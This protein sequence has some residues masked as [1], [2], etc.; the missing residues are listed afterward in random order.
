MGVFA[1]RMGRRG[2][3][4]MSAIALLACVGAASAGA[5][6]VYVGDGA[7]RSYSVALKTEAGRAYVLGLSARASCEYSEGKPVPPIFG[8]SAFPAPRKMR[9]KSRGFS[10]GELSTI[11]PGFTEAHVLANFA[12][13]E[14]TGAY[15]LDFREE[16]VSCET[17]YA[18]S[19]PFEAHR[20]LPIGK[21]RAVSPARGEVRVYYDHGGPTQFF[22]RATPKFVAGLRGAIV[23]ECPIDRRPSVDRPLPLFPR[24]AGA[25]VNGGRFDHRARI[26]GLMLHSAAPYTETIAISGR[27]TKEAVIGTYV[28]V[29]TT[30]PWH[31]RPQRCVTGPLKIAARRYLTARR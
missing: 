22:A 28:R 1:L 10:A 4:V 6:K 5:A 9:V 2:L 30:R 31:G 3:T 23:S 11:G 13:D 21:P 25:K 12:G 26:R 14:A 24:P 20:Y 7:K 15:R 19:F 16:S 18:G 8:L 29:H 27:E 17:G